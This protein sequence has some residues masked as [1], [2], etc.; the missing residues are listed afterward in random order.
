LCYELKDL[1]DKGLDFLT[2]KMATGNTITS[3]ASIMPSPSA[4]PLSTILSSSKI[5]TDVI[6]T[7]TTLTT[8][9]V[10]VSSPTTLAAATTSTSAAEADT[11]FSHADW[12]LSFVLG[13]GGVGVCCLI[14]VVIF[15]MYRHNQ[16]AK[17]Q[18]IRASFSTGDE[19]I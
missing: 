9:P 1:Y 2:I 5:I 3:V 19:A 7:L 6:L 10:P 16:L 13:L 15:T 14:P 12:A 4:T 17:K 8:I 18:E 11:R